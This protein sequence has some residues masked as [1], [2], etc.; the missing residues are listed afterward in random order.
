MEATLPRIFVRLARITVYVCERE[1]EGEMEGGR[2]QEREKCSE[3][4]LLVCIV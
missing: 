1:E 3:G 4:F 2:E